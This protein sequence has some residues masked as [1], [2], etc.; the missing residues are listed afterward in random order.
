MG[1]RREF[2]EFTGMYKNLCPR[3]TIAML[4]LAHPRSPFPCSLVS[5]AGSLLYKLNHGML[6]FLVTQSEPPTPRLGPPSQQFFQIYGFDSSSMSRDHH[7][8][9]QENRSSWGLLCVITPLLPE[10]EADA[11]GMFTLIAF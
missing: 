6:C 8:C 7:S 1:L 5:S 10:D 2:R 4:S 3:Q 11:F 9:S